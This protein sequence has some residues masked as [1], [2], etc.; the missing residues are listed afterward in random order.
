MKN[1]LLI[2]C[3][4]GWMLFSFVPQTLGQAEKPAIAIWKFEEINSVIVDSS[5]N[6]NNG[7][8]VNEKN[9]KRILGKSGKA[10]A[11]TPETKKNGC[12]VIPGIT[13]KYGFFAK[14][15]TIN[16]YLAVNNSFKRPLTYE[17]VSNSNGGKG[18]RL[19]ISWAKLCFRSGGGGKEG[20]TWQAS[21]NSSTHQIKPEI[22][23]H[24]AAVYNGSVFKVY[25]DGE[26]VGKSEKDLILSPGIKDLYIG[27]YGNGSANGFDGVIDE[28]RIYDYPRTDLQILQDAKIE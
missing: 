27:A 26:L 17:I 14:G 28:V 6:G 18:F 16:P 8:L 19:L 7:K 22:W 11:F 10:L 21:S 1:Q 20:K 13:A 25:L 5:G 15:I 2:G 4:S 23:Y 24:I 12:A 9:A 3:L